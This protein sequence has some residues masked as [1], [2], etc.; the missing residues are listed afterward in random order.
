MFAPDCVP[1]R[2]R[3]CES[4]NACA[5][6][7]PIPLQRSSSV[8]IPRA[9]LTNEKGSCRRLTRALG[10]TV[11]LNMLLAEHRVATW[12]V[13]LS[14]SPA[15]P[16]HPAQRQRNSIAT[17]RCPFAG[18]GDAATAQPCTEKRVRRDDVWATF[19]HAVFHGRDGACRRSAVRGWV[20]VCGGGGGALSW[21]CEGEEYVL[22]G[23]DEI[24]EMFSQC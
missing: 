16:M 4:C 11:L 14:S 20:A 19:V 8:S 3:L 17:R 21:V 10:W 1:V 5:P 2:L 22:L 13:P 6:A 15:P 9:I 24:I 12:L 23:N 7:R 18:E